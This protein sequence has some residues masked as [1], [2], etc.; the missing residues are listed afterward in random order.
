[1]DPA[2]KTAA[3][4]LGALGRLSEKA[5]LRAFFF[6]EPADLLACSAASWFLYALHEFPELWRALA[7]LDL[8]DDDEK[9][10]G[11]CYHG[12]WKQTVLRPARFPGKRWDE[13]V[14]PGLLRG[15]TAGQLASR[16][17]WAKVASKKKHAAWYDTRRE[18]LLQWPMNLAGVDRRDNLSREEFIREYERPNKPVVVTGAIDD[19]QAR[20]AW[21]K[22]AFVAKYGEV[23]MRMNGRTTNGRRFRLRLF[24]YMAYAHSCNAEKYLYTFDKKV[25]D[26]DDEDICDDYELPPFLDPEN[27]FA[28]MDEDD[29]PDYRWLLVGPHGSATPMHTDPHGTSAW[30]AVLDGCKR[31]TFYPP[32]VIPPGTDEEL[33]HSDYYASQD[34]LQWYRDTYPTLKPEELPVECLVHP[35]DVVYI[36]SGWWHSVLNLGLTI[37]ITENFVSMQNFGR[38]AKDINEWGS[39]SLRKDFKVALM[40]SDHAAHRELADEIVA[41]KRRT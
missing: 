13:Q 27:L 36:P 6:L 29:R 11:F 19:W 34:A 26:R 10:A 41:K 1:M 33:I 38:V 4:S 22:D 8:V 31:V 18:D 2:P 7:L 24:D 12:S 21:R 5:L 14:T 39:R 25:L 15:G 35:G 32:H 37:A 20:A 23:P 17:A 30:N 16:P 40:E 9:L 28:L 3:A